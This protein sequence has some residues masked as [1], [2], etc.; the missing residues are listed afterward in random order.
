MRNVD[1][2]VIVL[3]QESDTI[4]TAQGE[5]INKFLVADTSGTISLK[6]WGPTSAMIRIGDILRVYGVDCKNYQGHQ[7]LETSRN[8][9]TQ[10]LGQDTFSFVEGPNFSQQQQQQLDFGPGTS[11]R[12]SPYS[13][14]HHH[15][16]STTLP[17][18]SS[19]QF[20][21]GRDY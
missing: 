20:M 2:E 1:I 12:Q 19:P 5:T 16:F 13:Q 15:H 11:R 9:R 8:G 18:Y 10:R 4:V 6:A 17:A 14:H 3:Q 21:S 7:I